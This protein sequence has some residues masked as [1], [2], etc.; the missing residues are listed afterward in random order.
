MAW[1]EFEESFVHTDNHRILG[2]RLKPLCLYY[3][4]WLEVTGNAVM[5]PGKAVT[6]VDLEIACRICKTEYGRAW[7]VIENGVGRFEKWVFG[8]RAMRT[9]FPG[10][11]AAFDRYVQDYLSPPERNKKGKKSYAD[12]PPALSVASVLMANNFEGGRREAIWMTPL[13]EAHWWAASFMRLK[14]AKLDLVTDHDR[15]FIEGLRR[16]KAEKERQAALTQ[17]QGHES[18]KPEG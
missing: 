1:A 13:G 9:N 15:E 12:F 3:Q 6:I 10:A 4:F 14:G 16:E 11:M 8:I 5:I 2:H 17:G 7:D 18:P